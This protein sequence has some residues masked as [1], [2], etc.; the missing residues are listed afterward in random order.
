MSP[1]TPNINRI[2][3]TVKAVAEI[4][5]IV[6]GLKKRAIIWDPIITS[7]NE[8]QTKAVADP[9]ATQK[10]YVGLD[11]A[12]SRVVIWVLSPISDKKTI[13]RVD[14]NKRQSIIPAIRLNKQ[15]SLLHIQLI[16]VYV[17]DWTYPFYS[18]RSKIV[19]NLIK[20]REPF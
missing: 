20:N 6:L 7:K 16:Q 17:L 9:K 19:T 10:I 13:P 5:F 4:R 11:P 1:I 12:S 8:V 2:P 3:T 18:N 14:K 15:C